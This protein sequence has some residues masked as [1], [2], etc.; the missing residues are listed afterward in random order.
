M[1]AIRKLINA[2]R[3]FFRKERAVIVE[4]EKVKQKRLINAMTN[5][6]NTKWMRAGMSRKIAELERFASMPHWKTQ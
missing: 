3:L 1:N 6:Q 4:P 2:I 5:W